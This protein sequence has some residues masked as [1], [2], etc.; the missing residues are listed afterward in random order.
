MKGKNYEGQHGKLP[1]SRITRN[2]PY[3]LP[4]IGVPGYKVIKQ[5]D[6]QTLKQSLLF[7]I[8]FP[9]LIKNLGADQADS[10]PPK[11]KYRL[12]STFE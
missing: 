5:R 8:D 1:Q 4:K 11:P 7:E 9:E 6:P 3:N 2:R 12:M 10:L